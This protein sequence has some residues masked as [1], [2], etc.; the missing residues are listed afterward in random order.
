M[1]C[2]Y[3]EYIR[4]L[5]M[6]YNLLPRRDFTERASILPPFYAQR[7]FAAAETPSDFVDAMVSDRDGDFPS[8]ELTKQVICVDR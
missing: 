3:V 2:V 8:S 5:S 4:F 7:I 6:L 1:V